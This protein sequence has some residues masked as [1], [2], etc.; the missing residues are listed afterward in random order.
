MRRGYHHDVVDY[1]GA[2]E[3]EDEARDVL[4]LIFP[5]ASRWESKADSVILAGRNCES[6]SR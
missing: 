2:N 5:L 1:E 6:W 4:E 3:N